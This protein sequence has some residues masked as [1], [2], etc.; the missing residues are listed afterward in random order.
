MHVY[1]RERDTQG[2]FVRVEL[3][4]QDDAFMLI[5]VRVLVTCSIY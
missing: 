2:E 5:Y 4:T 1:D 3:C